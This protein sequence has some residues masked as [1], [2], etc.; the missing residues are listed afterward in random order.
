VLPPEMG[1]MTNLQE[2]WLQDNKL[3]LIPEELGALTKLK[4]RLDGPF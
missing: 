2:L 3:E 1:Q 4:V